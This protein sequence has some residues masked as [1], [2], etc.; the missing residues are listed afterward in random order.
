LAWLALKRRLTQSTGL[1]S[2][3]PQFAG[4]DFAP[5]GDFTIGGHEIRETTLHEAAQQLVRGNHAL[6]GE[7][8]ARLKPDLDKLDKNTRPAHYGTSARRLRTW[9]TRRFAR[10]ANLP[11]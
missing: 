7:L 10:S 1:V 9:P 6:D 5:W 11:A 8:I 2:E 4:L 3:L